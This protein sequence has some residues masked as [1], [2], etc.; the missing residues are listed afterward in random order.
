MA[1]TPKGQYELI[2]ARQRKLAAERPT[3][4]TLLDDLREEIARQYLAGSQRLISQIAYLL[5]FSEPVNFARS[6][7][8]WT[9][10]TPQQFQS[11]Q[12]REAG[13]T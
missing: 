13:S 4:K 1:V 9:G 8:R 12:N 3:Y 5:G 7:K 11:E 2:Y 6:F 10:V